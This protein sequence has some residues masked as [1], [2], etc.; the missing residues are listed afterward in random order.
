MTT[1]EIAM[2]N[3]LADLTRLQ[4]LQLVGF[5][6]FLSAGQVMLKSVALRIAGDDLVAK[7]L[8]ILGN[9]LAWFACA[10][11][12]LAMALWILVLQRVPLSIAYPFAALGF[13]I[14]PIAGWYFF[15]EPLD[16]RYAAGAALI[17][18]G[19]V[20]VAR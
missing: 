11:Y 15:D 4:I 19:I 6:A 13:V 2:A 16:L 3:Q 1:A 18:V 14:V 5:A 8:S 10:I 17:V 9:P 12:A 7:F 20:L